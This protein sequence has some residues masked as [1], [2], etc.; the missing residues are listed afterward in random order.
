MVL[1]YDRSFRE[2]ITQRP[3]WFW[4]WKQLRSWRFPSIRTSCLQARGLWRFE[5]RL[6]LGS[7]AR[8][9]KTH[10][11]RPDE[12]SANL[13]QLCIDLCFEVLHDSLSQ[14]RRKQLQ[15]HIS[16]KQS[17]MDG[18]SWS[19]SLDC[20]LLSRQ[21]H[22]ASGRLQCATYDAIVWSQDDQPSSRW[23]SGSSWAWWWSQ[24]SWHAGILLGLKLCT[25]NEVP[26]VNAC[27]SRL[28]HVWWNSCTY[29]VPLY[30][31]YTY[32]CVIYTIYSFCV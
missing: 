10:V 29:Y 14:V 20:L 19:L 23:T 24:Y 8:L 25:G 1:V 26:Q 22:K 3:C 9:F 27:W 32:I 16:T 6:F 31:V 28:K 5:I 30:I 17:W 15:Q 11:Q 21:P 13:C 7:V 18:H 12:I 4:C 2:R